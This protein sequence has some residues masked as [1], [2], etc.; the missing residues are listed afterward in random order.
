MN[1]LVMAGG[2]PSTILSSDGSS[3]D[4]VRITVPLRHSRMW[5]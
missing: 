2:A 4:I 5:K 1:T 3:D